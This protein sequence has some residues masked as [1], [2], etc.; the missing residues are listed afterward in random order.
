MRISE[1]WS[2]IKT[3]IHLVAQLPLMR[4]IN[5]PLFSNHRTL[6]SS[7]VDDISGFGAVP[8]VKSNHAF[9]PVKFGEVPQ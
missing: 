5:S 3:A 8:V 1:V 4:D 9:K 7:V 2:K 6:K